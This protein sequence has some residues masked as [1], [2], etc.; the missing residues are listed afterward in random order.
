MIGKDRSAYVLL[1]GG[2]KQDVTGK[3]V[4]TDLTAE[5]A[6]QGA[7]GGKLRVFA[8]AILMQE[9]PENILITGGAKGF[10]VPESA[11]AHRPPLAD[12]L[13]DELLECGVPEE[14]I[15]LERVSNTTFQ[16]LQE[17]ERMIT[18]YQIT[19]LSM[20]TN[21]WHVSRLSAIV[22]EKFPDLKKLVS[23]EFIAAEDILIA[24]DPK[25]WQKKI[26]DAYGA[27][28][29]LEW[30]RREEHGIAQIHAGT[31]RFR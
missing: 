19:H 1:A 20:I 24:H 3:W 16:E 29:M 11:I 15:V 8:T 5:D 26:N 10:D 7:P 18:D 14:R 28:F 13:R 22:D 21:R 6:A 30:I 23:I 2:I 27:A 12:I 17:I 31:Y 25:R 4:S 9:H